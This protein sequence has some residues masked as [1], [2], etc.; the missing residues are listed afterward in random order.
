MIEKITSDAVDEVV[1]DDD[2]EVL[3][4]ELDDTV[5]AD[6]AATAG[7]QNRLAGPGHDHVV[8]FLEKKIF[9]YIK[10]FQNIRRS[11]FLVRS[12][13]S[14]LKVVFAWKVVYF[15]FLFGQL[16]INLPT[17]KVKLLSFFLVFNLE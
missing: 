9:Y 3:L 1:D 5:G 4:E 15:L 6:V 16:L 8:R 17:R 2:L 7:H 10:L 13:Q 11:W 12:K 14:L